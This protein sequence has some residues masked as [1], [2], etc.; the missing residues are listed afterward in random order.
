MSSVTKNIL[1][2]NKRSSRLIMT[3]SKRELYCLDQ[4]LNKGV[5][6][7]LFWV[8]FYPWLKQGGVKDWLLK[9]L[10]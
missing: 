8:F 9:A 10:K 1:L 5:E 3:K 7:L 2:W 6:N 4:R